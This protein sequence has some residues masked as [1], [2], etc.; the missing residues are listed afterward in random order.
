MLDK[1]KIK[2]IIPTPQNV[3]LVFFFKKIQFQLYSN[4][5]NNISVKPDYVTNLYVRPINLLLNHSGWLAANKHVMYCIAIKNFLANL[6]ANMLLIP[7][8]QISLFG[9]K[10]CSCISK[11][12]LMSLMNIGNKQKYYG[13]VNKELTQIV[14]SLYNRFFCLLKPIQ[15]GSLS[16]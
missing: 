6:I 16:L 8:D 11:Y 7:P 1:E 5:P 14:L 4:I 3:I 12:Q 9:L 2:S 10:S 13:K 15:M